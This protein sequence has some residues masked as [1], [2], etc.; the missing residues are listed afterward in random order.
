MKNEIFLLWI[1]VI[2]NIFIGIYEIY[3][4]QNRDL[5]SLDNIPK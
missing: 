5:L 3:C 1:W 2:F 4:F